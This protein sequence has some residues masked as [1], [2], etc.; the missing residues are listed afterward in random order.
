MFLQ[1]IRIENCRSLSDIEIDFT[2]TNQSVRTRKWTVLVG[3]NGT[4]KS[5]LLKAIGLLTVGSSGLP[6]VLGEP[7]SWVRLGKKECR[8]QGTLVT[9]DGK[10]RQVA[11]TIG[12]DDSLSDVIKRND[13]SLHL[14]DRAIERE[15]INYFVVGYGPYRHIADD[16]ESHFRSRGSESRSSPRAHCVRSLFDKSEVMNPLTSWAMRLDYGRGEDGLA[17]VRDA[18]ESLLPDV[19]FLGIDRDREA[20]VFST[21]DGEV[22]LAGLSDG[23][24]NVAAWIGD[25]LYQVTRN[26]DHYQ[27]P[28]SARGV[29]LIDEIDA[30]LHPVWQRNLR[31]YLDAKLPNLQIV[32][33]THSALTLQQ[34]EEEESFVLRR[35][36]AAVKLEPLGVDPNRLR[37][38]QLYDL[39]FGIETFD[40]L[41]VERSK[42]IVR[43]EEPGSPLRASRLGEELTE[44]RARRI[45][46]ETFANKSGKDAAMGNEMLE[47]YFEKLDSVEQALRSRKV[48]GK[49]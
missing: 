12:R 13:N 1:Y 25:L 28:L 47:T 45:L 10:T 8:I 32:A 19:E 11:L 16:N 22:E 17:V 26:F 20:L 2:S 6:L 14:L 3:E 15:E 44:D 7:R 42:A 38:H 4:G 9:K 33:S 29:L 18:M 24:Q 34:F 30:H 43:G 35:R 41:V 36:E 48:D 37:L 31:Q 5:T 27:D 21:L 40:S 39:A 49:K 23:Y 46:E